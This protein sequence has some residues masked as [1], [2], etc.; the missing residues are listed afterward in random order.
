MRD[1]LSTSVKNV[2]MKRW[3][4]RSTSTSLCQGTS[5]MRLKRL[6]MPFMVRFSLPIFSWIRRSSTLQQPGWAGKRMTNPSQPKSIFCLQTMRIPPALP[7]VPNHIKEVATFLWTLRG[8]WKTIWFQHFKPK[9]HS[10]SITSSTAQ[11]H[12]FLDS[13]LRFSANH[14]HSHPPN[15]KGQKA[16]RP[17]T[18]RAKMS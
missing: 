4:Q 3:E 12:V 16:L 11:K 1:V 5:S 10:P 14:I 18:R 8:P 15:S 2:K 6:A 13:L 9:T 17:F 7:R